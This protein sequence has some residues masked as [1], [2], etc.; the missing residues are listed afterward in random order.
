M[1]IDTKTGLEASTSRTVDEA[2]KAKNDF[3]VITNS[4]QR[5]VDTSN[6]FLS[7]VN[8]TA[9]SIYTEQFETVEEYQQALATQE[10]V[11]VEGEK[12]VEP[13][14]ITKVLDWHDNMKKV[15]DEPTLEQFDTF[16]EAI[17]TVVDMAPE[18]VKGIPNIGKMK[19]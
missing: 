2:V 17:Q 7:N 16:L 3:K 5:V 18:I 15:C 14:E 11:P 4:L 6:A 1:R 13:V 8:C 10:A 19:L 12:T 9:K